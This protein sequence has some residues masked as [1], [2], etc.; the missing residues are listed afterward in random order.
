MIEVDRLE[1]HFG[2]HHEIKAVA[3]ATFSAENGEITGLLGPNGAGKTTLLRTLAT[4]IAPDAGS[5]SVD[6]LDVI[7]DRYAVRA[8]IGVLSDARGLY[9][10]LTARENVRYYGRLHGLGGAALDARVETLLAQF[11]LAALADRRAH[12]FSQGE[13]MKVAIAR[14]LVHDPATILLDEP[15]NGLD[16]MSIRRLRELLRGLRQAGKCILFSTHVMQEVAALCDTVVIL[17]H[18]RVVASGS[19]AELMSRTGRASLEDAF[20]SLLG[21]GEGLAA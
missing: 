15:T 16:I 2:K 20:V 12:G 4:L 18:G 1:K 13:R 3:G 21:S 14:A 8:R 10:R 7:R 6:G 5:A 19:G 11:G 17:G 9:A